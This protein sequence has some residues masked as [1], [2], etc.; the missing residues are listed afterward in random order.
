MAAVLEVS[1]QQGWRCSPFVPASG[2]EGESLPRGPCC[3]SIHHEGQ[4][5]HLPTRHQLSP[6]VVPP[7]LQHMLVSGERIALR[8]SLSSPRRIFGRGEAWAAPAVQRA[9]SSVQPQRGQEGRLVCCAARPHQQGREGRADARQRPVARVRGRVIKSRV[10]AV[11]ARRRWVRCSQ[12]VAPPRFLRRRR[13]CAL[14][15][16]GAITAPP[17]GGEKALLP[18]RGSQLDTLVAT[19]LAVC[20]RCL[21]PAWPDREVAPAML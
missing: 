21:L 4:A 6:W 13:G 19:A 15:R 1:R 5:L 14:C 2:I 7:I 12:P 8:Y 9:G 10:I 20:R 11:R 3:S 17:A 18:C 16:Q